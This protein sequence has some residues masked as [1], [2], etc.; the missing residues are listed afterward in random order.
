MNVL[1]FI[2]LLS[3]GNA[4]GN[5]AKNELADRDA[6]DNYYQFLFKR[7]KEQA[8]DELARRR[9]DVVPAHYAIPGTLKFL[10]TMKGLGPRFF[11]KWAPDK[12]WGHALLVALVKNVDY[13]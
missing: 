3:A 9:S 6:N 10:H 4:Y 11:W 5:K 7:L 8:K 1:H 13:S 12:F 2:I